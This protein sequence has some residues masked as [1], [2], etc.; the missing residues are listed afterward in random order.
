MV[1]YLLIGW[2]HYDVIGWRHRVS[3]GLK[4]LTQ[5]IQDRQFLY[6]SQCLLIVTVVNLLRKSPKACLFCSTHVKARW[7]C[8]STRGAK[9]IDHSNQART[10]Q[11]PVTG[12]A[13]NAG[14]LSYSLCYFYYHLANAFVTRWFRQICLTVPLLLLFDTRP[15]SL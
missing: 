9:Y 1:T 5:V 4:L 6:T 10:S 3:K 11:R 8:I 2:R 15:D 12:P 13:A 7:L 14:T